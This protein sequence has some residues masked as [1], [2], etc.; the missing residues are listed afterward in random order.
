[1][2]RFLALLKFAVRTEVVLEFGLL[3]RVIAVQRSGA[4]LHQL[5]VLEVIKR[6]VADHI[7][8]VP[9]PVVEF[10]AVRLS[11]SSSTY[12]WE[13]THVNPVKIDQDI[14]IRRS[15]AF[16]TAGDGSI[17]GPE[18]GVGT[19]VS[20]PGA[21]EHVVLSVALHIDL[22][23]FDYQQTPNVGHAVRYIHCHVVDNRILD[24]HFRRGSEHEGRKNPQK[25]A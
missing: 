5:A 24:G 13:V 21:D 1:M 3:P 23:F 17:A 2:I 4:L 20:V 8:L 25:N 19:G 14:G 15:N 7:R 6:E 12:I 18:P 22:D 10:Q 9:I 16:I 11:H